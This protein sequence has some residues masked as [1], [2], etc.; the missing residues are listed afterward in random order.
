MNIQ[1]IRQKYPQYNDLSD[2]SLAGAL[3]K[4]FYSDIPFEDFSQRVGLQS[5][6]DASEP[7]SVPTAHLVEPQVKYAKENP[8]V[9]AATAASLLAPPLAVPAAISKAGT[10]GKLAVPL[11]RNA[12]QVFAAM[13]GGAAGGAAKEAINSPDA[14]LDSIIKQ[15]VRSGLEMGAAETAGI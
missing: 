11:I 8:D 5:G 2:T 3:H 4:K 9:V 1:E 10:L 15:S 12:P 13:T 7:P 6:N 14:T